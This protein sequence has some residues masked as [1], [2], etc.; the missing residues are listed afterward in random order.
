MQHHDLEYAATLPHSTIR[1][2]STKTWPLQA[3]LMPPIRKLP[4][5]HSKNS[6]LRE[7]EL[8][9][10]QT[11]K[12]LQAPTLAARHVNGRRQLSACMVDTVLRRIRAACVHAPMHVRRECSRTLGSGRCQCSYNAWSRSP[13]G[14]GTLNGTFCSP[15]LCIELPVARA[16][17]KLPLARGLLGV[18]PGLPWLAFEASS[19]VEQAQTPELEMRMR[20]SQMRCLENFGRFGPTLR[21]S[22]NC[23][24]WRP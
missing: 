3:A 13:M 15:R 8:S 22:A 20:C 23:E 21:L 17:P 18:Q 24:T 12:L 11:P 10:T 9:R 4:R 1:T 14:S 16:L 7:K 6:R 5:P 19:Q 2:R